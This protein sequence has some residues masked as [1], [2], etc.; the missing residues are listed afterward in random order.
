ML[1][2]DTDCVERL[3]ERPS[4]PARPAGAPFYMLNL[5]GPRGG[6]KVIGIGACGVSS[7]PVLD[8]WSG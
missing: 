6:G 3:K 2:E 8:S 4:D 5:S 1:R 7:G